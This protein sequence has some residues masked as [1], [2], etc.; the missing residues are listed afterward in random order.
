LTD[1]VGLVIVKS[2]DLLKQSLDVSHW[3]TCGL[4]V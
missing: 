2:F 4:L 3:L 1:S